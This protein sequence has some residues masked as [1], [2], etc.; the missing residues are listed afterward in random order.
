MSASLEYLGRIQGV[1]LIIC[2]KLAASAKDRT[3]ALPFNPSWTSVKETPYKDNK[4]IIR[5]FRSL[6]KYH[7]SFLRALENHNIQ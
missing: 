1:R 2:A 7:T 5:E 4:K 3:H 6:P